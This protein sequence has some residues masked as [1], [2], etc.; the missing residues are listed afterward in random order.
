MDA[1]KRHTSTGAAFTTT[2]TRGSINHGRRFKPT[3]IK[4]TEKTPTNRRF[5]LAVILLLT[6]AAWDAWN[7]WPL[8]SFGTSTPEPCGD[9]DTFVKL[10]WGDWRLCDA[11]RT[12]V[13]VIYARP[14]KGATVLC[15]NEKGESWTTRV[16]VT[17]KYRNRTARTHEYKV[18]HER[19]DACA[20]T[21]ME[22]H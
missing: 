21:Y 10:G 16:P 2:L 20:W 11:P 14:G 13:L 12:N 18:I 4:T 5:I 15:E 7:A 3:Y 22:V 1:Y 17:V 19:A 6:L 9:D 8:R